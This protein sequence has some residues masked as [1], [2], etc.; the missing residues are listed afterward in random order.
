MIKKV[1]KTRLIVICGATATGKTAVS[2]E[3]AKKINGEI[4]SC[5]SMQVYKKM[6]I[7]TAK[8]TK[9]EMESIP[10]HLIDIVSVSES[11]SAAK[12]KELALMAI[13]EIKNKGKEPIIVGGTGLYLDTLLLNANFSTVSKDEDLRKSLYD[14]EEKNG[15][16]YL[17]KMLA[18]FD[19]LMA[20]KLP[21]ND[22]VRL[23]RA[24][25]VYKLT[26]ITKTEQNKRSKEIKSDFEPI[27]ICLGYKNREKL[28]E[29]INK[30][31]DLMIENGLVQEVESLKNEFGENKTALNGIGY[32]EILGYL[33]GEYS[34]NDAINMIK[35]GSRH[36]AKRQITWFKRY[37]N[38]TFINVDE[39]P[40]VP[41]AT[42]DI[43]S[44]Y[45][46][47]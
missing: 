31:V 14:L 26:G 19:P 39:T 5:D 17:K 35:Q 16:G 43:L 4:I 13:E 9:Q 25:E 22:L 36:Y 8:V 12:Y 11:F 44:K 24:I 38:A 3:V 42:L 29:N 18:E 34:L 20:D 7:G 15:K 37:E 27:I 32:K 23:V 2:V 10:H 41:K 40:D 30:R 47:L 28:Y 46:I 33:N 6:D 1:A 45:G 21:E